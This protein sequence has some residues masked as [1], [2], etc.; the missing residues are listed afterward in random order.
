MRVASEQASGEKYRSMDVSL[1]VLGPA[2]RTGVDFYTV[3][4]N[5]N[6]VKGFF[7]KWYK[8]V[9]SCH[10]RQKRRHKSRQNAAAGRVPISPKSRSARRSICSARTGLRGPRSTISAPPPG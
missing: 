4:H 5:I 9:K 1:A 6:R 8:K 7:A 10:H 3:P 2:F